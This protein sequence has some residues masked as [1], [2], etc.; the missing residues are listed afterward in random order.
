MT[1]AEL[2]R[3]LQKLDGNARVCVTRDTEAFTEFVVDPI[4]D[5]NGAMPYVDI[6]ALTDEEYLDYLES[7][8]F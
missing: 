2:I 4:Q 5:E 7:G 1:V 6:C 3:D 8:T